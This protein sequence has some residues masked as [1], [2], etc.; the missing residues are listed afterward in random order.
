MFQ[1]NPIWVVSRYRDIKA[2]LVD[3]RLSAKTLPDAIMPTD[4][5]NKAP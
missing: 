2:A 5:D 4:A 3:P 1:G